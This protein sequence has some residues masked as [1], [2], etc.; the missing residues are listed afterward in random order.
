MPEMIYRRIQD[1]GSVVNFNV[2]KEGTPF[3]IVTYLGKETRV[4]G[5]QA[6][7]DKKFA[8]GT[9]KY[10]DDTVDAKAVKLETACD[11]TM[12]TATDACAVMGSIGSLASDVETAISA[13]ETEEKINELLTESMDVAGEATEKISEINTNITDATAKTEEVNALIERLEAIE[14]NDDTPD[15]QLYTVAR[16]ELETA[17]DNYINGVSETMNDLNE[18]L[19]DEATDVGQEINDACAVVSENI[20]AC[21]GELSA[22]VAAVST[23]NCKGITKALQNTKFTPSGQAGEI[24]EKMKSDVPAQT[25]TI[26]SNGTIVNWNIDKKKPFRDVMHQGKLTRVYATTEQLDKAFPESILVAV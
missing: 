20:G 4:H 11:A 2:D 12:A 7:L 14:L 26:Q 16:E 22:M 1:N 17:L 10:V 8:G 18:V 23:G 15:P 19:G 5:P 13:A 3:I 9:P 6:A 24:K 25:R 21:Q